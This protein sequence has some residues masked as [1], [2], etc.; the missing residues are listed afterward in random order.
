MRWASD[1][2]IYYVAA[3]L[4]LIAACL[5]FFND[6]LTVRPVLGLAMFAGMAMI[7]YKARKDGQGELPPG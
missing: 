7:G 3:A 6:G 1:W 5:S 2:R 4:F